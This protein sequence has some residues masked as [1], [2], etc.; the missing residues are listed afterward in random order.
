MP[1]MAIKNIVYLGNRLP[2]TSWMA[3]RWEGDFGVRTALPGKHLGH[4]AKEPGFRYHGWLLKDW[5]AGRGQDRSPC[6]HTRNVWS[7][8]GL[9]EAW[10]WA[11]RGRG[12]RQRYLARRV[13]DV[14]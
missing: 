12:T 7:R 1:S 6:Q 2:L 8:G 9:G 13:S 3:E 10:R 11:W 5:K 4:H 14:S